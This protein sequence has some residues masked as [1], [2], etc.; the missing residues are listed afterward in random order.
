MVSDLNEVIRKLDEKNGSYINEYFRTAGEFGV[1]HILQDF[2]QAETVGDCKCHRQERHHRH[3]PE[4]TQGD[5]LK[6]DFL[7]GE[8]LYCNNQDFYIFHKSG[9]GL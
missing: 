2:G 3:R 5:R 8:S 1:E 4:E 6:A 9:L 7:G